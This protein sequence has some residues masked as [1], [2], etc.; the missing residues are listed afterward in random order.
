MAKKLRF[1]G[2]FPPS[3]LWNEY[4]NWEY[5]LDEETE[6][7]Q[8]ETTLRP[9][10]EKRFIPDDAA[11]TCGKAGQADGSTFP[12]FICVFNEEV[13]PDTVE[14]IL[15]RK[16]SYTIVF[17][18]SARRWEPYASEWEVRAGRSLKVEPGDPK[19]F[20]LRV[21]TLL[22]RRR[23]GRPWRLVIHPDGS[24]TSSED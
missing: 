5:A 20:P 15:S 9:C 6:E 11:F 10:S 16:L 7:D 4:P 19:I 22:P 14:V 8:D 17:N 2:E 13:K 24:E 23:D 18:I 12:A 21:E 1:T 3:K